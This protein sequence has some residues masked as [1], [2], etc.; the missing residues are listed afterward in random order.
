MLCSYKTSTRV[1]NLQMAVAPLKPECLRPGNAPHVVGVRACSLR[2]KQHYYWVLRRI[3][4][5][6]PCQVMLPEGAMLPVWHAS[7]AAQRQATST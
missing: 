1:R 7:N 3:C 6:R 4:Q 5:P 2:K